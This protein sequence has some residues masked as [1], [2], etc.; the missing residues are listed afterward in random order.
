MILIEFLSSPEDNC[1]FH[2]DIPNN[3]DEVTDIAIINTGDEK[4]EFKSGNVA[5]LSITEEE[6]RLFLFSYSV[7]LELSLLDS[8]V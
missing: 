3:S 4:V 6:D 8:T 7:F 5:T 1:L 2:A